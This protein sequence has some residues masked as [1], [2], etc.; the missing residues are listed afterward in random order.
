MNISSH[1]HKYFK[2][3]CMIAEQ[4]DYNKISIIANEL[5]SLRNKKGR[6]FFIGVGGS[7]ANCSHAVNDFRKICEIDT[8]TPIDNISELTARTNDEG[9]DTVF[10]EWLKISNANE[11]D[12]IFVLSVGGG[13][14]KK[15]ISPNIVKAVDEALCRKLKIFGIVGRK[16][17]YTAEKGDCVVV[18]P[19]VSD[20]RITP[21]SESFQAVIWH[22]LVSDPVLAIKKTKW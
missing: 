19:A 5:R 14:I 18:V 12:A 10:A 8:Y 17:G 3:V 16:E 1:T 2:E 6:L 4:L 9:W 11:N 15:N 20:E 7:A 22:C 21:H 13:D